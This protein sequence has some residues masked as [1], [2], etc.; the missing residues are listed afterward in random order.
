MPINRLLVASSAVYA[1]AGFPL[2]FA[3]DEIL[4]RVDGAVSPMGL[5]MGGMLGGA[6]LAM[7][8]LNWFNRETLMGGIYGR[9]LLVGNLMLLTNITFSALRMWRSGG[10]LLYAVTCGVGALLLVLF[11]RLL[12]RNPSGLGRDVGPT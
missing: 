6:L 8:L 4:R 2:M 11:G 12:F 10:H 3:A 1:A 5:W 9:P 7:A